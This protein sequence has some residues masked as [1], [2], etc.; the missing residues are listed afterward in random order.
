[1]TRK[2][3]RPGFRTSPIRVTS[4]TCHIATIRALVMQAAEVAGFAEPQ[5]SQIALAVDEALAN[6]IR[7]GY[8]NQPGQPIDVTIEG[9][10][11]D[12]GRALQITVRDRGKHVDPGSIAPRD[13]D[14]VRPGGLG[15]HIIRSVM[16]EVEYSLRQPTGMI[17][18]MLK[19]LE[20]GPQQ[21]GQARE[22]G[23]DCTHER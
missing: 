6:V 2:R 17:L 16:D 22:G 15:T 5:V 21:D 19:R 1:M 23:E 13:L 8:D 10:M 4:D 7:H 12:D 11:H 3:V 20:P 9:V 18:R 14:D